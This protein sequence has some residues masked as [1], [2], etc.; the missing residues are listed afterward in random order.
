M[1]EKNLELSRRV[2]SLVL[3]IEECKLTI[4]DDKRKIDLLKTECDE[5]RRK[6]KEEV[7]VESGGASEV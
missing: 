4:A 3:D 7:K 6:F 1:K 5:W 2:D